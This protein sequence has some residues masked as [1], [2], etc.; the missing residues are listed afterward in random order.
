MFGPLKWRRAG[1]ELLLFCRLQDHL[2]LA[3]I[4]WSPASLSLY[5]SWGYLAHLECLIT[6]VRGWALLPAPSRQL[7]CRTDR[8]NRFL[9]GSRLPVFAW[10][11]A[12]GRLLIDHL[13]GRAEVV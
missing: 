5:V 12:E 8:D 2:A 11:L 7:S 9:C 6:M 3:R 13:W 4:R 10:L 1:C